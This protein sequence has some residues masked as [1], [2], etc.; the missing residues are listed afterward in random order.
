MYVF[1]RTELTTL[2]YVWMIIEIQNLWI[3]VR[4]FTWWSAEEFW[5]VPQ[6]CQ[7]IVSRPGGHAYCTNKTE[8]K[9]RNFVCS[10]S[11]W[12]QMRQLES[13]LGQAKTAGTG[14]RGI[15]ILSITWCIAYIFITTP[16]YY[17]IS[18]NPRCLIGSNTTL[19]TSNPPC[20]MKEYTYW[21][22]QN[23]HFDA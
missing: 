9:D 15:N 21:C 6:F 23:T 3:I 1:D 10:K 20:F 13:Q 16:W 18:M 2:I 7:S 19:V 5:C 11:K 17:I 4:A 8:K 14:D 12:K 22:Q